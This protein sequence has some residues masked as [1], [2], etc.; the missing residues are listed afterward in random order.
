MSALASILRAHGYSGQMRA[1][2]LGAA[3]S[4]RTPRQVRESVSQTP[5]SIGIVLL[6]EDPGLTLAAIL[7]SRTEPAVVDGVQEELPLPIAPNSESV[8]RCFSDSQQQTGYFFPEHSL[9]AGCY[10][11]TAAFYLILQ[12]EHSASE[13]GGGSGSNGG[14]SGVSNGGGSGVSSGSDTLS[15]SLPLAL[16]RWLE[17]MYCDGASRLQDNALC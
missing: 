15:T 11:L 5:G 16:A 8:L 7:P 17:W 14:G 13:C 1:F 9:V 6:V 3:R 2:T 4:W 12:R 10:P